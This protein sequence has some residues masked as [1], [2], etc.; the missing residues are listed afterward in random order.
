MNSKNTILLTTMGTTWQI[1]PELIGFTNP[2]TIDLYQNHSDSIEI[3]QLRKKFAISPVKAVWVV[4]T[5][6]MKD[7]IQDLKNWHRQVL[8]ELDLRIFPCQGVDDLGTADECERMADLIFRTALHASVTS[9]KLLISLAGGRKTMSAEMQRAAFFFGCHALMHVI[10]KKNA[11]TALKK[12]L[13]TSPLP[14]EKADC[15]MPLVLQSHIPSDRLTTIPFPLIPSS[16]PLN[17]QNKSLLNEIKKRQASASDIFH[18]YAKEILAGEQSSFRQLYILSPDQIQLLKQTRI[19][20]DP[21]KRQAELSWLRALPKAELHCHFG[22]ILSPKEMILVAH[23]EG[24]AIYR[25]RK[26]S[27]EFNTWMNKIETAVSQKDISLLTQELNGSGKALRHKFHDVPEPLTVCGFLTIFSHEP[28]LLEQLIYKDLIS[29]KNFFGIGIERYE[30]LG[31]LQGSGLLQSEAAI[32]QACMIL[33]RQTQKDNISYLELRCSPNNYTRGGLTGGQVVSIILDELAGD[34]QFPCRFQLIF[35]ASRHGAMDK[36][37]EHITLAQTMLDTSKQ[38]K[39]HFSGFDLAGAESAK[40]PVELRTAFLPLMERCL[41]L[42]IHAGENESVENIWQAVYHLSAD[43]I[44][45]GLTLADKPELM[46]RFIDRKIVVELCPSS[47]FQIVGYRDNGIAVRSTRIYPLKEYLN[48]GIKVTIN[49]DD[50]GMSRTTLSNE[51]LRAAE[52]TQDGLS[53]WEILQLIRNGY[54]AAF[55]SH[56]TKN[57]CLVD[58]ETQIMKL[59][60]ERTGIWQKK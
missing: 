23:A 28:D 50:P 48:K 57:K 5:A 32:R 16:Y 17:T 30:P 11:F 7:A 55:A 47:N 6:A 58:A 9:T 36:I 39:T 53:T 2:E 59:I 33:K 51:Y 60:N 4:T 52:M 20:V 13:F 25:H 24:D 18:N 12:V 29:P 26:L 34:G 43:R 44:G 49:T 14:R 15:I 21:E 8:P 38:F 31:D 22:G 56:K 54:R 10:D 3:T 37:K 40:K 45:H 35:I 46:Q 1:I 42:T 27:K 41:Q 19:G